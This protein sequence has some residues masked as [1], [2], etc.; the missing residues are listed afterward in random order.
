ML[1]YLREK[2][3]LIGQKGEIVAA[4][5]TNANYIPQKNSLHERVCM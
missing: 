1:I 2:S 4:C 5:I 3:L